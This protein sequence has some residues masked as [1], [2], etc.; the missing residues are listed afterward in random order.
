[1]SRKPRNGP[2]PIQVTFPV[3]A[4]E[5]AHL[6]H[7]AATNCRPV[8]QQLRK[9]FLDWMTENGGDWEEQDES[10]LALQS[11]VK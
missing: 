3:S 1:M 7:L 4:S 5:Q 10:M 2:K 6:R 11:L 9:M 8:A